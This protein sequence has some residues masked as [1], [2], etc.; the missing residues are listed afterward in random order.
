MTQE[1][2]QT[3]K[4]LLIYFDTQ[5]NFDKGRY[6]NNDISASIKILREI[7]QKYPQLGNIKD[8]QQFIK[9]LIERINKDD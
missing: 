8:R 4:E 3:I 2:K 5:L 6:L 1:T 7:S 9:D